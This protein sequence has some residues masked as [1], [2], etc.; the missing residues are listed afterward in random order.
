[1]GLSDREWFWEGYE[2][3]YGFEKKDQQTELNIHRDNI[4]NQQPSKTITHY[5]KHCNKLLNIEVPEKDIGPFLQHS[6]V[7]PHCGK[8][9]NMGN[10]LSGIWLLVGMV[11]GILILFLKIYFGN[12]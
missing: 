9:N 2:E 11:A 6:F 4:Q 12:G 7:C 10:D 1:M 5:C 8:K 3:R